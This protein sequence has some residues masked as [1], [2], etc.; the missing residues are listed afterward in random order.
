MKKIII[1]CLS[2]FSLILV[3]SCCNKIAE[4]SS[5][6]EKIKTSVETSAAISSQKIS[7]DNMGDVK[8]FIITSDTTIMLKCPG[9]DTAWRSYLI[10][11][12]NRLIIGVECLTD[13]SGYY[14]LSLADAENIV[15]SDKY[16]QNFSFENSYQEVLISKGNLTSFDWKGY[17]IKI[18]VLF[19]YR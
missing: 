8:H 10:K 18:K 11:N 15:Y 17:K 4:E 1:F 7:V 2:L 14:A 6:K 12:D 13:E 19:S 3:A 5:E 16:Y 9:D